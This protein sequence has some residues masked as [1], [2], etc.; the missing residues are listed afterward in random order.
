MRSMVTL[1]SLC[2]IGVNGAF[3]AVTAAGSSEWVRLQ[4]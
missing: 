1:P 2:A 4:S 3:A